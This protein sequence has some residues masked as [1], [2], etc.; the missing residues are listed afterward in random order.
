QNLI[1]ERQERQEQIVKE[2]SSKW[3]SAQTITTPYIVIPY[4]TD[5]FNKSNKQNLVL[6]PENLNVKSNVIPVERARSIY[7]VLLYR[8]QTDFNGNFHLLFPKNV[9]ATKLALNEAQ[10]CIGISDFKGIEQQVTAK[11]G[12]R[13]AVMTP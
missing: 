1:T 7:N 13:D 5:S 9:D 2:V 6:L 4:Y 11:I 8:S 12:S 3:A 10:L